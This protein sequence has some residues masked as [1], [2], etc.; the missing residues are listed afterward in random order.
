M[1]TNRVS[2]FKYLPMRFVKMG[3]E[4]ASHNAAV[5]SQ[6]HLTVNFKKAVED[7]S[8]AKIQ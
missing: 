7:H 2:C 4:S 5:S 1:A 6:A 8:D 3:K